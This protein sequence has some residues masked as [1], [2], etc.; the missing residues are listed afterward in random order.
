MLAILQGP[1][2][3]LELAIPEIVEIEQVR[4]QSGYL[5]CGNF[6]LCELHPVLALSFSASSSAVWLAAEICHSGCSKRM[7]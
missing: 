4:D 2:G 6:V 3:E 5:S 7:R 1:K